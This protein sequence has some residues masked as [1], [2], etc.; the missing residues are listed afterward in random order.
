MIGIKQI[1]KTAAGAARIAHF[2]IKYFTERGCEVH[3]VGARINA[4]AVKKSGGIPHRAWSFGFTGRISR[5]LYA[6]QVELWAKLLKVDLVIGHGDLR[7]QDI[8][9]LHN[10]VHLAH[11]CI[12]QKPLRI[13]H[14]MYRTHTPQLK[15]K[16]FKLLVANSQLMRRDLEARFD[17]DN[18]MIRVIYPMV[19]THK[20]SPVGPEERVQIR[21]E[22]GFAD[23][24]FVV[25]LVTSGN[26]SKRGVDS[27][28]EA[29]EL[30]PA[31]SR[32]RMRFIL[33]GKDRPPKGILLQHLE[34][35]DDV[36]NYY[37]ALDLFVLPARI[38]EFGLVVAEAMAC[39][40]PILVSQKVGCLELWEENKIVSYDGTTEHMALRV[41]EFMSD[42][43]LAAR[44]GREG[45]QLAENV[46]LVAITA[47]YDKILGSLVEGCVRA[48]P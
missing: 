24:E 6:F 39:G 44:V 38:E 1:E 4:A 19:D 37:R 46:D 42:E 25:G 9:F 33:V 45:A 3:V 11:E 30:I 27:F 10:C 23:G 21:R 48:G 17:I 40:T 15:G 41:L 34:I 31:E 36:E 22:L 13:S 5:C 16:R 26:F 18:S 8:L 29:I 12:H 7:Y 2:Q 35:R 32:T 43:D 20:F 14:E 47:Q 28:I